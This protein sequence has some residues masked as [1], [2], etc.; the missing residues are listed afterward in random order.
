MMTLAWRGEAGFDM[1]EE[2]N[3]KEGEGKSGAALGGN[4]RR[5]GQVRRGIANNGRPAMSR[6]SALSRLAV[7]L[8]TEP[9]EAKLVE[10]LPSEPGWQF[11]PKWDGFRCLAFR[12]GSEVT[13]HAKSGKPL[14][15]YFP[16]VVRLLQSLPQKRFVL[17]GELVIQED[18]TFSFDALQMRLHPAESRV[19]KLSQATPATFILFDM[20]LS[21]EGKSLLQKP[22]MLRCALLEQFFRSSWRA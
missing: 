19:R 4:L 3:C 13:L 12:S 14:A 11:E 16:E 9:M 1:R 22:L 6:R 5:R 21:P 7:P 17:D 8:G 20:L 10:E 18:A 15:R 2:V